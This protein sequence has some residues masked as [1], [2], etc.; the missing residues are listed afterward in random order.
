MEPETINAIVDSHDELVRAVQ[1]C[2]GCILKHDL[3]DA[4]D[5]FMFAAEVSPGFSERAE[6]ARRQV[7][8]ER[9]IHRC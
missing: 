9:I 8:R 5:A 3:L 4:L 1:A 2:L 6:V 7:M